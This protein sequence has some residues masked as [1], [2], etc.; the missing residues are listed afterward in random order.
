MSA[1]G[2][3]LVSRFRPDVIGQFGSMRPKMDLTDKGGLR[4]QVQ[5]PYL[6]PR[7]DPACGQYPHV[8]QTRILRLEWQ[9]DLYLCLCMRA[10]ACKPLY[11]LDPYSFSF[12]KCFAPLPLLFEFPRDTFSTC[13][14][15]NIPRSRCGPKTPTGCTNHLHGENL[16]TDIRDEQRYSK[17]SPPLGPN[18]HKGQH[19]AHNRKPDTPH[20]S[21]HNV[22]FLHLILTSGQAVRRLL[23]GNPPSPRARA[24]HPSQQL[25][26]HGLFPASLISHKFRRRQTLHGQRSK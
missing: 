22:S 1:R 6:A 24:D 17:P 19:L 25:S 21:S 15:N 4:G 13:P 18:S 16:G 11:K 5:I 10:P 3:V 12:E 7:L 20:L 9:V 14:S 8:G 23:E 2:F 26:R